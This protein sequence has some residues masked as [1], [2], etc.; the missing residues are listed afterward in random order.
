M[1][2][3]VQHVGVWGQDP[4]IDKNGRF[5]FHEAWAKLDFGKGLFA[6]IGRQSLAYDDER[7]LGSLD[8]NVAGRFHDALKL[9]YE[10][11]LHKL[12]L[13]LAY[14]QKDEKTIGGNYYV[15]GGQPYKTM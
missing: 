4:Q 5:I 15:P 7:L 3:A 10:N 6:Q 9:G 13:V 8:W 11:R 2:L 1:K 14:N 12:H